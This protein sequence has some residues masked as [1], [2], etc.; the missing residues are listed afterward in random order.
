LTAI[1]RPKPEAATLGQGAELRA[2]GEGHSPEA[3]KVRR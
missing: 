1:L 3:P 2:N